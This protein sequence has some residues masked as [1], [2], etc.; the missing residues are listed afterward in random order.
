MDA[1]LNT[2]HDWV[3]GTP[4]MALLIGTGLW[5][6]IILRGIQFRGLGRAFK[7]ISAKP[8]RAKGDISNF[9]SLMTALAATVG[10]GN[11]AGVATAIAAGGPGAL[12]WMWCTGIVG[13]ATKYAEALLAVHYR[14][15]LPDGSIGGGPMYYIERGLGQ[16][17]LAVLFAVFTVIASFGIGNM[18]QSN[19]IVSAFPLTE[20]GTFLAGLGIAAAVAAVILGGLK[21]LGRVSAFLVPIMILFYGAA[22]VIILCCNAAAIPH[23]FYLILKGAFTPTAA[24]GGFAGA[25]LKVTVQMGLARGLFSNE[26]GM[27]SAPIVAAAAK[28]DFAASQ[29]LVSMLQTTIDTLIVCSMT[30]FAILVTGAWQTD[31]TGPA[32]TIH[33]FESVFGPL[34]KWIVAASLALFA[35]STLIGWGYY[36]ERALAYLL[37]IRS[38]VPYRCVFIVFV[39][40]G[41]VSKL[42]TVWTISDIFNGLMALPNLLAL[43][44]LTP[45]IIEETR[46]YATYIRVK[47]IQR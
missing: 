24:A 27:G 19:A 14:V 23:A 16:K 18:T 5:I 20:R 36:G 8:D 10:V 37:G 15:T 9:Q 29:A 25:A 38:L 47:P 31:L 41:A 34:G 4:L 46:R 43:L 3:W 6:T 1:F 33:A 26:A 39:W 12:F 17:W 44:C 11:I 32:L 2:I 35:Y 30:G 42:E 45:V 13:G 7:L 28:T 22:V 21:T 40:V